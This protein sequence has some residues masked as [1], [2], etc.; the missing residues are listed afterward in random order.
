MVKRLKG[1]LVFPKVKEEDRGLVER[2]E[3]L[4]L[5]PEYMEAWQ[6]ALDRQKERE[7]TAV[8]EAEADVGE[9]EV[10]QGEGVQSEDAFQDEVK[11][12]EEEMEVENDEES[13][14][15]VELE[16]EGKETTKIKVIPIQIIV[17]QAFSNYMSFF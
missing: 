7:E 3:Q 16:T 8:K 5:L 14:K 13:K 1:K 6:R 11:S 12:K 4:M 17:A 9:E 10:E 2:P 15:G